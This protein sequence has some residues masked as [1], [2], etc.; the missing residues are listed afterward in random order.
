M[1]AALFLVFVLVQI[2]VWTGRRALALGVFTGGMVL[3]VGWFAHH[4]TD[5]LSL[6]F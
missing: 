3:A 1:M 4:A 2:L 6:T 5:H